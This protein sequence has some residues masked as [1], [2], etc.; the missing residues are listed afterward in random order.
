MA[1]QQPVVMTQTLMFE[2]FDVEKGDDVEAYFKRYNLFCQ[3]QKV[4]AG[5]K[6]ALLLASI[7]GAAFTKIETLVSP[8]DILTCTYDEV[9]QALINHCKPKAL[10]TLGRHKFRARIQNEGESF[11]DFLADLK[12]LS[13]DCGFNDNARIEE[14]IDQ[15]IKGIREE[16]TRNHLLCTANL[17]YAQVIAKALADEK[18]SVTVKSLKMDKDIKEVDKVSIRDKKKIF[19]KTVP[20]VDRG[21]TNNGRSIDMAQTTCFRCGVKEHVRDNCRMDKNVK[22]YNCERLG[23]IAKACG[24]PKKSFKSKRSQANLVC[25]NSVNNNAID[26]M[27]KIIIPVEINNKTCIM[28]V[29]SGSPI[30]LISLDNFTKIAPNIQYLEEVT[31]T[32]VSYTKDKI[33]VIDK[34]EVAVKYRNKECKGDLYVVKG[35]VSTLLGREWIRKLRIDIMAINQVNVKEEKHD[36]KMHVDRL[37]REY[38]EIF[39]NE[40]GNIKGINV[41][42]KVKEN[43][44]PIHM[45][46]RT[47]PFALIDRVNEEI[48]RLENTGILEKV[49]FSEWAT[50]IVPIVKSNGTDIRLCGDYKVTIN[51]HIIPDQ[52]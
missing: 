27:D 28:E 47:I 5:D 34:L 51:K 10:V 25:I 31:T 3:V 9:S 14:L 13:K 39:R 12:K 38:S 21:A 11:N 18:T 15:I 19:N 20:R 22:C 45:K 29:N 40:T 46:P 24:C 16:R 4:A 50:P 49:N 7:G 17:T 43:T 52:H 48:D 37:I 44:K 42:I 33:E 23:H 8:K 30:S 2:S 35:Q 32:F 6:C 36:I 26:I 1:T 41:D